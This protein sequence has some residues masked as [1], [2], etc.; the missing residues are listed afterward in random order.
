VDCSPEVRRSRLMAE[1]LG[2]RTACGSDSLMFSKGKLTSAINFERPL[3]VKGAMPRRGGGRSTRPRLRSLGGQHARK[4]HSNHKPPH[5]HEADLFSLVQPRWGAAP[6]R[7]LSCRL[8]FDELFW[9]VCYMLINLRLPSRRV[10]FPSA[11]VVH[12]FFHF[13]LSCCRW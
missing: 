4:Q 7:S 11:E 5:S 3:S 12:A 2:H 13:H 9:G 10:S 1:L 8:G 6:A